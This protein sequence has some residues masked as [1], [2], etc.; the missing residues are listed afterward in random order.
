MV[1][2]GRYTFADTHAQKTCG[3]WNALTDFSIFVVDGTGSS[4]RSAW[5]II[6][7][8]AVV[9]FKQSQPTFRGSGWRDTTSEDVV[10]WMGTFY[11]QVGQADYKHPI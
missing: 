2:D 8:K 3:N 5:A 10:S 4:F 1:G 7:T 11:Q 9:F 6:E